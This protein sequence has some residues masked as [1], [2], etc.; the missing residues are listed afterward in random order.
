MQN[1]TTEVKNGKL[2]ITVDLKKSIGVSKSGKSQ[3]I[4]SSQGNQTIPGADGVKL[5]LN[6]YQ[7][8]G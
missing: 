2:V 5:G 6:V 4:A 1:I 8:L 3:L 7:P